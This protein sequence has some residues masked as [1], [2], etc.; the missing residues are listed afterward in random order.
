MNIAEI[1]RAAEERNRHA[2]RELILD[3]G[4]PQG[5]ERILQGQARR[6]GGGRKGRHRSDRKWPRGHGG[7]VIVASKG[8]QRRSRERHAEKGRVETG[9]DLPARVPAVRAAS[10]GPADDT[11]PVDA[12]ARADAAI[13]EVSSSFCVG[14]QGEVIGKA[15]AQT[16]GSG[17]RSTGRRKTSAGSLLPP[18]NRIS[19][20]A[21]AGSRPRTA[22]SSRRRGRTNPGR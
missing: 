8:P 16:P 19:R 21:K 2:D 5:R 17:E 9:V 18:R 10:K 13:G 1:D 11:D 20:R 14:L 15:V 3:L 6:E 7:E 4:R 12:E 22:G